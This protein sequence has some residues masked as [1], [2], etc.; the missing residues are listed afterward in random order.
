M[1]Q[2]FIFNTIALGYFIYSTIKYNKIHNN[3][4]LEQFKSIQSDGFINEFIKDFVGECKN[5]ELKI[6]IIISFFIVAS[7]LNIIAS[8]ISILI[9]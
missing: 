6:R 1:I 7:A 2:I 5:Y 9:K 4:K 3:K 8:I